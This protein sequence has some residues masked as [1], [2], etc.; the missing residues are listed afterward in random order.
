MPYYQAMRQATE[1]AQDRRRERE[2]VETRKAMEKRR[3]E[4]NI[5]YM[6]VCSVWRIPNI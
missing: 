5:R 1:A 2:V 3:Q 6:S 4:L